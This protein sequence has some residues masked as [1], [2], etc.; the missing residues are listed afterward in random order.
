MDEIELLEKLNWI[1]EISSKNSLCF[2][3]V[4]YLLALKNNKKL[5]FDIYDED[6]LEL[7]KIGFVSGNKITKSGIQF[8]DTKVTVKQSNTVNSTLPRLTSDTTQIVKRLAIHFL[9]DMFKGNDF[10]KYNEH[11]DNPI[12]APFFFMFMNM[13]PSSNSDANK[14]WNRHF[15]SQWTNVNLRRVTTMTTKKF[16]QIWKSK[17]IGL[18]LLGT[19]FFIKGSHNQEKNVYFVKSLENFWKE[20]DYWYDVASDMLVKGELANFTKNNKPNVQSSMTML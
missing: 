5:P 14:H 11:C 15:E 8:L 1:E 16:K 6:L 9:A 4:W 12:M 19:Y 20:S 17:D 2:S 7:V 3:Q 13:F 10:K 18:F